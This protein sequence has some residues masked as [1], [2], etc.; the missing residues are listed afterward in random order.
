MSY[1]YSDMASYSDMAAKLDA[2][3]MTRARLLDEI[4]DYAALTSHGLGNYNK[5]PGEFIKRMPENLRKHL[6]LL[7]SDDAGA[8]GVRLEHLKLLFPEVTVADR[9][10]RQW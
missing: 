5:T 7:T 3:M 4:A 1:P 9:V 8:H 10:R 6:K 2:G